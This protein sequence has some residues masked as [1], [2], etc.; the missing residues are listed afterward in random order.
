MANDN[1]SAIT[2]GLSDYQQQH[3]AHLLKMEADAQLA[4]RN[5]SDL[6]SQF[7]ASSEGVADSGPTEDEQLRR[8][9]LDRISNAGQVSPSNV[10]AQYSMIMDPNFSKVFHDATTGRINNARAHFAG[11]GALSREAMTRKEAKARARS[12]S[13]AEH[14]SLAKQ[15]RDAKRAQMAFLSGLANKGQQEAA[16]REEMAFRAKENRLNRGVQRRIAELNADARVAG[17]GAAAARTV[18]IDK[19]IAEKRTMLKSLFPKDKTG[20]DRMVEA[21][22]QER[23]KSRNLGGYQHGQGKVILKRELTKEVKTLQA[24]KKRFGG[25]ITREQY[26]KAV[27]APPDGGF[28]ITGEPNKSRNADAQNLL[29][30]LGK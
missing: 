8:A 3:W 27:T 2:E 17:R 30:S 6:R 23:L 16:K 12:R 21:Q 10:A 11:L 13:T 7:D 1:S 29:N 5:S 24:L 14:D 9:L 18:D 15:V 4:L 19:L 20:V 28:T 22:I 25:R 26:N